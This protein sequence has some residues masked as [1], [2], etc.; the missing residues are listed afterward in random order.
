[1]G[2]TGISK[3]QEWNLQ[4]VAKWVWKDRGKLK[5]GAWVS[6]ERRWGST[7]KDKDIEKT[8][9]QQRGVE[10][11]QRVCWCHAHTSSN[12]WV[13]ETQWKSCCERPKARLRKKGFSRRLGDPELRSIKNCWCKWARGQGWENHENLRIY[14]G[15]DLSRLCQ[16]GVPNKFFLDGLVFC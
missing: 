10:G 2:V 7:G 16:P 9:F 8:S 4:L 15:W 3:K 12:Q 6:G 1:M 11:F 14:R 5:F 13:L